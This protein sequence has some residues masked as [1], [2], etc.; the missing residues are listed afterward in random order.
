MLEE[1]KEDLANRQNRSRRR[2][3]GGDYRAYV[4]IA[5]GAA[6]LIGSA[7]FG[8]LH[9]KNRETANVV[10]EPSEET[11]KESAQETG[12]AG[13]QTAVSPEKT[14]AQLEE[15]AK[16]AVVDS[17]QNLGIIQ[18]SGYLNMRESASRNAD[19]I[20]KLLGDS[21]CEIVDDSVEG[22]YQVSSG[23]LTGYISSEFVLRGDEA[24][25]RA[26]EL[27]APRA[28]VTVD[29]LNIRTE[30]STDADVVGQALR[31]ERYIV[32]EETAD[33]WLKIQTGYISK[34][35]VEIRYALNEA[36]KLDMRSMVLNLYEN[37]GISSVDSY[38]NVR[39]EPSED[40]K[41]IGKMTSKSAGEIL[42]KS[43][44]GTWYKIHSGPVTGY[45]KAEYIL[46]GDAARAEALEVA[47]LMAIVSTDRLNA[48]TEPSTESNI[49]TQI[50]SNERYGVLSQQDGWVEIDLDSSTAFVSTDFVDVRY[51]LP[52][53][54]KFS[55]LDESLS[56]RNQM[57]NYALQFVGNR[58]VWGGND[59]HTGA[60]CSGFVK[61]VYSHV[62]GV[63]LNRVSRDQAR[64]GKRIQ[65]SQMRPGD[66]IFYTNSKG[67]VNH[68]AM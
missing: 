44:D 50:S 41:I 37:I 3:G 67:V 39:E 52:E 34:D 42:E 2:K 23:G 6:V 47:E 28:V 5:A 58:Y 38:L 4:L 31:N 46:T 65:S 17:Y 35:Y 55:P 64:Q 48:R 30:P 16:A 66:L 36:R 20:G 40:G 59:P 11:E 56:L 14:A 68:V 1:K 18:V 32:E 13:A 12:A 60:D 24:R 53:A 19:I 61:Y 51:A 45:V 57:V 63:T 25:A 33:G 26:M 62:A 15:A 7:V 27:V 22:W 49:W 8:G 54:I 10:T 9:L 29:A 21:A 43:E